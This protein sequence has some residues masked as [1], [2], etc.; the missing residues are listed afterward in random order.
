MTTDTIDRPPLVKVRGYFYPTSIT[1]EEVF[2]AIGK[3]RREAQAKVAPD[4]CE[5]G[6]V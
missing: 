5:T 1:P 4:K 2:Q 6:V 3:L